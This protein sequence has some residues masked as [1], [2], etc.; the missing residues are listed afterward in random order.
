MGALRL[1]QRTVIAGSGENLTQLLRP[2]VFR[3]YLDYGAFESMRDLKARIHDDVN[4]KG[5]Q[6]NIKLGRARY[7]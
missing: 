4:R 6:D 7:S 1:D 5:M 3:K 2:F